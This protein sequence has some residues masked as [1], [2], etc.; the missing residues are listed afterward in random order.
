MGKKEESS[1]V[2]YVRAFYP[3][4]HIIEHSLCRNRCSTL[5]VRTSTSV[6]S[7]LIAAARGEIASELLLSELIGYSKYFVA[8]SIWVNKVLL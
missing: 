3:N 7:K 4:S 1:K 6:I 5:F 2:V 8:G